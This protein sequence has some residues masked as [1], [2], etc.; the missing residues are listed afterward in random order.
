M[1]RTSEYLDHA[2]LGTPGTKS[3]DLSLRIGLEMPAVLAGW[4]LVRWIFR[5]H[6]A[7]HVERLFFAM[8]KR[9]HFVRKS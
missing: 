1:P 3:N 4:D 2:D 8:F 5:T 9:D 6:Y 7:I